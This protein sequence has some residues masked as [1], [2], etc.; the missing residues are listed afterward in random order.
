[1]CEPE[2]ENGEVRRATEILKSVAILFGAELDRRQAKWSPTSTLTATPSGP[3]RS[4]ELC[5]SPHPPITR[6]PPAGPPLG[7]SV[8]PGY[9]TRSSIYTESTAPSMG[10]ESSEEQ[11]SARTS[12]SDATTSPA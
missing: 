12:A 3:S 6:G 8:M 7:R 2:K 11:P 5:S 1:M 10:Q 9:R 4:A